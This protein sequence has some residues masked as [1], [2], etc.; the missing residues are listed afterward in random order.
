MGRQIAACGF[1]VAS[2]SFAAPHARSPTDSHPLPFHP[3]PWCSRRPRACLRCASA[4]ARL[5]LTR[6]SREL[7]S[8]W[9]RW[10]PA[11]ASCRRAGGAGHPAVGLAGPVAG[12]KNNGYSANIPER[13]TTFCKRATCH[14]RLP[15]R[16][17]RSCAGTW[18]TS[19]RAAS[20]PSLT[21]SGALRNDV[22]TG[23]AGRQS[24]AAC[25]KYCRCKHQPPL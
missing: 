2:F 11:G 17:R 20:L 14:P 13:P 1:V 10:P 21:L 8:R 18:S 6:A 23:G 4:C 12:S 5:P 22:L 7:W 16:C 25:A 24:T 3:N 15:Y 19:A 9:T